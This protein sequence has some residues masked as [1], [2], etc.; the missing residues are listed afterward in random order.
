MIRTLQAQASLVEDLLSEGYE[1]VVPHR[2]QSDP[3]EKRFSRYRQMSGGRYLVSLMEVLSSE[4]ILATSSLLKEGIS[5]WEE[6][7]STT[8]TSD[9]EISDDFVTE[10]E[11]ISAE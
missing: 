1:F 6:E 3:L 2:M 7:L 10:V 5:F 4:R 11:S 9:N 8:S